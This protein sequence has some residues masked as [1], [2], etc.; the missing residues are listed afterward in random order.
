[1]IYR[2]QGIDIIELGNEEGI[3]IYNSNTGDTTVLDE[4]AAAVFQCFATERKLE[5]A[6]QELAE[7]YDASLET[8]REDVGELVNQLIEQGILAYKEG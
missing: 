8:L 5:D 2:K 1:M 3:V 4:I 6:V 7:Q